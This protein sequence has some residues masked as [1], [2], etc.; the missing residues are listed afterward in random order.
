MALV[1]VINPFSIEIE[2][3]KSYPKGKAQ[4]NEDYRRAIEH[5]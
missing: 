3:S 1:F 4:I 5:S 2:D